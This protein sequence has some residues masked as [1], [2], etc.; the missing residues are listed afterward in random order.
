[1]NF[2]MHPSAVASPVRFWFCRTT[3]LTGMRVRFDSLA[4]RHGFTKMSL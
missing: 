1:V 2:L 4:D 3:G